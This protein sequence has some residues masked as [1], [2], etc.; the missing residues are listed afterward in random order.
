M[1]YFRAATFI[2]PVAILAMASIS[3]GIAASAGSLDNEAAATTTSS[4]PIY[5]E[6]QARGHLGQAASLSQVM[7][8]GSTKDVRETSCVF[9]GEHASPGAD[10][11]L[12][13][14]TR[15]AAT[16][17]RT[18]RLHRDFLNNVTPGEVAVNLDGDDAFLLTHD[19]GVEL[20]V[21]SD[22]TWIDVHSQSFDDAVDVA[23][24][25][26]SELH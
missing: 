15:T 4:C 10:H 16:A 26:A 24:E 20:R 14:G 5:S 8:Y 22:S 1:R 19:S 18:D 25:L 11:V 23:H 17:Q 21:W 12:V 6:Q 13:V 3:L 2:V 7:N 9:V